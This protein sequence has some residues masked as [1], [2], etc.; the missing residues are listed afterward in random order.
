MM[1]HSTFLQLSRYINRHHYL[2]MSIETGI[3]FK[4]YLLLQISSIQTY[5]LG[6]RVASN[7]SK[8]ALCTHYICIL[9]IR[10]VEIVVVLGAIIFPTGAIS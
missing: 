6:G 3:T 9:C 5:F 7:D 4:T 8:P 10:C 1:I 2:I